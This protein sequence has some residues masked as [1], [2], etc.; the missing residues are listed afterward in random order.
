MLWEKL[1]EGRV[2]CGL[3]AHRCEIKEGDFGFCRVRQ[4]SLGKL[5]T[6]VYGRTVAENTDPIE[7]KPLYHFLPGSS[8]YSIATVGCNFRCSF[9]QNW[10][11]S[12]VSSEK[13]GD[14]FFRAL[15]EKGHE[16]SPEAIVDE[17][18]RSGSKSIAY[19]YTE[20]TVFFEYAH[21]TARIARAKG[22]KNCFVT[23]GFMTKEAIDK[24]RP[25]LDAANVDLKF[26]KDDTYKKLCKGRLQPVLDSIKNMKDAGIW[27]E[28]TTL[29]IPGVND[30]DEE[31]RGIAVFLARTG[32]EIP[33][34]VSRFHP[35][36]RYTSSGPTP[37]ETIEKAVEIGKA[38]GL[39]YV[40]P[41][42]V[43]GGGETNC[44]ACGKVLIDRTSFSGKINRE[45]FD[46]GK[47]RA[48]GAVIEGAWR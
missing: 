41:G 16:M 48:C 23:N 36:Y 22:L 33:W 9:C 45:N 6:H 44:Y 17:A 34:H 12:Q 27:V 25:Y 32:K 38:E 18:E 8:A 43:P 1:D 14:G 28:V 31:L 2:R 21:D 37:L 35:D 7:K 46:E 29:V 20:P 42:N 24:I 13:S 40:Y 4:N 39:K 15:S 3:C 11:I 19:T 30:T 26:F 5:Y 47:C 10:A